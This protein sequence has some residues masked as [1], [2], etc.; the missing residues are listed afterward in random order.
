MAAP[1]TASQKKDLDQERGELFGDKDPDQEEARFSE[2][3]T[4]AERKNAAAEKAMVACQQAEIKAR[5]RAQA[6]TEQLAQFAKTR[7]RLAEIGWQPGRPPVGAIDFP[8]DCRCIEVSTDIDLGARTLRCLPVKG[9]SPGGIAV[10]V[11][12]LGALMSSDAL[13]F[14]YLSGDFCPLYFTGY[15]DY[16]E[17]IDQLAALKPTRVCPA[18]Q[19]PLAGNAATTAFD[20]ASQATTALFDRIGQHP[21]PTHELVEA[22]YAEYYRETFTLYSEA[23]IRGCM[24]LLVRRALEARPETK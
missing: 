8:E 21:D 14:R 11:P 19:G 9:H 20:T 10:H 15:T 4:Q 17:T 5:T 18:H 13:G 12:E 23:N 6:L 24:Q 1:G 7:A 3:V 2:L 16:L 22:L